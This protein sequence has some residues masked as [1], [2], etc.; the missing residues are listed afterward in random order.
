MY[1][2]VCPPFKHVHAIYKGNHK[3]GEITFIKKNKILLI[4]FMEIYPEYRNRYYGYKVI[5]Y[6]LSHYKINCIIGETL[7]TARGF[8]NKCIQKYDGQRRNI[9]YSDNCSSSFVIPKYKITNQDIYN[10]LEKF[11]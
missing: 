8:W 7:I 11:S 9:R 2:K 3:I 1:L 5:E 4:L 10:L 6:L